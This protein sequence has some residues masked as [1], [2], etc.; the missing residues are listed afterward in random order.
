MVGDN[1]SE[2]KEEPGEM[3]CFITVLN[4]LSSTLTQKCVSSLLS[5]LKE[6]CVVRTQNLK[7]EQQS[8]SDFIWCL[9]TQADKNVQADLL[10]G[11]KIKSFIWAKKKK[12]MPVSH[13]RTT[14]YVC[15]VL[16]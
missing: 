3:M 10:T 11:A 16:I 13:I 6:A 8:S 14:E 12:N 15:G 2:T 9:H 4:T 7:V 1:I 5:K